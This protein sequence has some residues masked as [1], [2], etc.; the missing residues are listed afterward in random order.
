VTDNLEDNLFL[1]S[2]N[3]ADVLVLQTREV[4]PV[5]LVRF[6]NVLLTKGALKQFEEMLG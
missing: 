4:D 5:S 6:N 1:S 2:R 3:L